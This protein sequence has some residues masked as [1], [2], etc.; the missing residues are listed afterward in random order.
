MEYVWKVNTI[1]AR[2]NETRQLDPT[3]FNTQTLLQN[4]VIEPYETK[5]IAPPEVKRRG[6]PRKVKADE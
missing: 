1:N 2:R 5:E 6:R 3:C 4:G